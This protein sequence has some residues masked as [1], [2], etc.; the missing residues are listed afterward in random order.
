MFGHCPINLASLIVPEHHLDAHEVGMEQLRTQGAQSVVGK[1]R[2]KLEAKRANGEVFPV[3]LA[4]QSAETADGEIFISF[5]RDISHR[6]AAEKDLVLARDRALAGEKNKT[7]FLATMSHEIRTPLNGL[8]GN[9]TLLRDTELTAQQA[10]YIKNMNVSGKLLK[11][12]ISDVLDITKYDAGKLTLRPVAMNISTLVQDIVDNQSATAAAKNTSVSWGWQG[13]ATDWIEADDERIQHVLMNIVGN[14]VKFTS[15][16]AVTVRLTM[17]QPDA[18]PH[19]QIT[20]KD[21]GIGIDPELTE[22]IFSDF[23]TGDNSYDR[24]LEGTGLGLGI[25]RR[26]VTAMGGKIE[27]HSTQGV[28]SSFVITF[29]VK[30]IKAPQQQPNTS[31]PA[32]SVPP[33]NVLLVEDNEINR[34][35]AREMLHVEGHHVTQAA[36]GQIAVEMAYAERFDLILM[37]ISMPV[38]DGRTATRAIRTGSGASRQ[39]PIVALT[40]NAVAE[41][42]QAFLSDGMNEVITKPLSRKAL[43]RLVSTIALSNAQDA[44]PVSS[45][46]KHIEE[47]REMLGPEAA[48]QIIDRFVRETD[49]VLADLKD[50]AQQS[51]PDVASRAH[52]AA[53]SA[54]TMGADDLRAGL[55][56]VEMAAKDEDTA[57]VAKAVETLPALWTAFRGQL[58]G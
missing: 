6:V 17:I 15:Q 57:A 40:A 24:D 52:K 46:N 49:A 36:N 56:A 13:P 4:V 26:F 2:V 20:V 32:P 12:H 41:E 14:A 27:V 3:E 8:L 58:D 42:Q 22:E 21:T 53:G 35:V 39:T 33:Q 44:A 51:L 1:G 16:G 37:D 25:A 23:T 50:A 28:G 43:I 55:I 10:R 29:P 38:M 45:K 19:L 7:D 18:G 47:L 54:A 48:G 30:P 31:A 34:M 11:R 5:L 9:L